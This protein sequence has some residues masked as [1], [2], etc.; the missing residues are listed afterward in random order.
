MK[1]I[2]IAS[3]IFVGLIGLATAADPAIRRMS[4]IER[5]RIFAVRLVA[6]LK[7][8]RELKNEFDLNGYQ[9]TFTDQDFVLSN[10]NHITQQ[11]FS[12]ALSSEQALYTLMTSSNNF[13]YS[14]IYKLV[15]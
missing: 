4:F 13:H 9:G 14:N 8:L 15:K 11:E 1:K 12:Q 7:D 2:I 3:L 6:T 10:N 5:N